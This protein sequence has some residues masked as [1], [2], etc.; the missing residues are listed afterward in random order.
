M[1]DASHALKRFLFANLYRHPQ[2][3]R[4]TDR[5]RE[6]VRTLFLAYCSD[7]PAEIDPPAL[8]REGQPRAIADFIAG[9]T[10]R[11]AGHAFERVTGQRAFD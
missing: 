9:M 8:E 1:R 7:L 6:V 11:Y 4:T 10:D 2:V 5:A 3:E